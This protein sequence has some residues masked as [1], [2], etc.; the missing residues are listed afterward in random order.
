MARRTPGSDAAN[1]RGG[2]AGGKT[3]VAT[4]G[5]VAAGL[6]ILMAAVA[7]TASPP[8]PPGIAEFAPQAAKPITK[9]PMG[10]VA[11]AGVGGGGA[12]VT[13]CTPGSKPKPSAAAGIKS[14]APRSIARGV[15][16][17]LQCYSWPDGSVTQTFDPQSP[18]CV[19]S[20]PDAAKGNGG[21]TSKGV[22]A[23][24]IRIGF[25]QYT[26]GSHL[27]ELQPLVDFI[28][29]HFQLYG[30]R[31]QMVPFA[32]Q[33]A[34]QARANSGTYV[35][36]PSA[37]RADAKL[38]GSLNLFAATDYLDPT[39]SY[40]ALPIY[41]D[42]LAEQRVVSVSGG[43]TPPQVTANHFDRRAPFQWSYLP[44]IGDLM[45]NAAAMTCKQL[46]DRPAEHAVAHRLTKRKIGLLLPDPSL[47]GGKLP[48]LSAMLDTLAGCGVTDPTVEYYLTDAR[49]EGSLAQSFAKFRSEETTSLLYYP[50]WSVIAAWAPQNV[51]TKMGYV[52][53][54]ITI[55][56]L[57]YLTSQLLLGS[58]DQAVSTF[59]IGN[60]NKVLPLS[61][62]PGFQAYVEAGGS[63][64]KAASL[65][66]AQAF[67][68]ELL[69]IAAGVQMAGPHLT[70]EAFGQALA[71][72][73]FP[74]PGASN[75][76]AYQARVNLDTP[77]HA[78]VTDYNG[79]WLDTTASH[80]QVIQE[81]SSQ[82]PEHAFCY[83]SLGARWSIDNWPRTDGFYEG[84]CR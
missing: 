35:A 74:S 4:N 41:F 39:P 45:A 3:V 70:P 28:N 5:T 30:R 17:S 46:V 43:G 38:A 54:W 51:A 31:L 82:N 79:F 58:T 32:S 22:T 42:T 36:D 37:Q 8:A 12:C 72:T 20:W 49:G 18:P 25:P 14:A 34:S 16:S 10:Q 67:Y 55:G 33:Q 63:G 48:G 6:V 60:W 66:S 59:G 73:R 9:A 21:E 65:V 64:A 56:W 27:Q 47:T 83:A 15:P 71:S 29:T 52:P 78:M 68:R 26:R 24:A 81:S 84:R 75:T 2:Q 53:E 77:A 7:L 1:R 62:Q 69:V 57:D 23:T 19:A 80:D 13:N 11:Q 61:A 76:P 50:Y 44:P 40:F